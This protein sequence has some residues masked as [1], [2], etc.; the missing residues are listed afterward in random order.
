MTINALRLKRKKVCISL[1]KS[2][3]SNEITQKEVTIDQ[4]YKMCETPEHRGIYKESK[5]DGKYFIFASFNGNSRSASAVKKYYGLCIDIDNSSLTLKEI[6]D[7]LSEYSFCLYTTFSHAVSYTDKNGKVIDKGRRYRV[8]IPYT[9]AIGA[10]DHR[11]TAL[12]FLRGIFQNENIDIATKTLSLPMYLPATNDKNKRK[13]FYHVNKGRLFNPFDDE[14]LDAAGQLEFEWSEENT[15]GAPIDFSKNVE[16]GNRDNVLSSYVGTLIAKGLPLDGIYDAAMGFNRRKISPPLSDKDITRIVDSIAKSNARNSDDLNWG[17]DEIMRRLENPQYVKA[18]IDH[19]CM[20][21]AHQT[22]KKKLS[23]TEIQLLVNE[24]QSKTKLPKKVINQEI[25]QAS[26]RVQGQDEELKEDA[27]VSQSQVLKEKFKGWVY[28]AIEDRLYNTKNGEKFTKEAF[29]AMFN[30]PDIAGVANILTKY[31]LIPKVSRIEFD[32]EAD[33]LYTRNK[34]KCAN[35]YI[36]ADLKPVR[37]DVGPLLD[38]FRYLFPDSEQRDILLD[39]IAHVVQYPGRKIRWMPIIKGVK[40]TGKTMIASKVISQMV[41]ERFVGYGTNSLLKSPFNG[42]MLN[43]QVLVFEEL[44]AG[45]SPAQKKYVT[46]SLKSLITDDTMPAHLKGVDAYNV[47]NKLVCMGFTNEEYSVIVTPDER[48]FCMLKTPAKPKVNTYYKQFAKYCEDNKQAIAYYFLNRDIEDF[49]AQTAPDT[50][51]TKQL[52]RLSLPW[53]GCVIYD[54]TEELPFSQAGKFGCLSTNQIID[55]IRA[56]SKGRE[57]QQVE[58]LRGSAGKT[59]H[60]YL[61]DLG[62]HQVPK[63]PSEKRF[64]FANGQRD[65][66]WALPF[67]EAIHKAFSYNPKYITRKLPKLDLGL[68]SDFDE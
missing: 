21:I 62:Y 12:Y 58:D 14:V 49:N 29:N 40:G 45:T 56:R 37:G 31:N 10:Q 42:W 20:M 50:E 59:V 35:A 64:Y 54:I 52:K 60:K 44:D 33:S 30:N 7:R 67:E 46:D 53:P 9:V 27:L 1:G 28:V 8:I 3:Y 51:Y 65:Y 4:L 6:C 26:M 63:S 57:L 15:A 19:I 47:P 18:S 36:P 34:I 11:K 66:V 38:H 55:L 17:F 32:P 41:N 23:G 16:E 5:K 43:K 25:A 24:I 68:P 48:R 61:T 22:F 2:V 13:F 39:F